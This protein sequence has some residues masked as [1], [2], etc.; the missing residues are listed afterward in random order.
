MLKVR[1]LRHRAVW[2]E[3]FFKRLNCS[4]ASGIRWARRLVVFG[5]CREYVH[6]LPWQFQCVL[7]WKSCWIMSRPMLVLDSDWRWCCLWITAV[8]R[9]YGGLRFTSYDASRTNMFIDKSTK[10]ICQGFT[11][12]QVYD[13]RHQF[14]RNSNIFVHLWKV[15][16]CLLCIAN[17]HLVHLPVTA[18]V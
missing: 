16:V 13:H 14:R 11:G 7:S 15:A 2:Q 17:M 5:D 9:C 6:S 1:Q 3:R 18:L 4:E 10:V 12:K 8:S